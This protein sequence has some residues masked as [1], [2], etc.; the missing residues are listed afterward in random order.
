MQPTHC[1]RITCY[2]CAGCRACTCRNCLH[3]RAL[4]EPPTDHLTTGFVPVVPATHLDAPVSDVVW[5]CLAGDSGDETPAEDF[6][7]EG[8]AH[9]LATRDYDE[10]SEAAWWDATDRTLARTCRETRARRVA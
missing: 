2:G 3:M 8:D 6:D 7:L 9:D 1:H 5:D 4:V 10:P